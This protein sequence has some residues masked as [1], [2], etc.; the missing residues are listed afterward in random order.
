MACLGLR[1]S[2]GGGDSVSIGG[3][4][5]TYIADGSTY[6]LGVGSYAITIGEYDSVSFVGALPVAAVTATATYN[7]SG[8]ASYAA[9]IVLL[10]VVDDFGTCTWT[11]TQ[12]GASGS[13]VYDI[14]C[15]HAPSASKNKIPVWYA[16]LTGMIYVGLFALLVAIAAVV[17]S[18]VEASRKRLQPLR[19]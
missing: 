2:I 5:S 19:P 8:V 15:A 17:I 9:G 16:V 12:G 14:A 18:R 13:L 6:S 1:A 3:G 7:T 10:T 11:N 4:D